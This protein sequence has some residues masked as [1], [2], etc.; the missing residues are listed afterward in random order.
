MSRYAIKRYFSHLP[1]NL[2]NMSSVEFSHT[3]R[4]RVDAWVWSTRLAK[5]RS[6]AAA[7]CRSGHVKVNDERVKPSSPVSVGD[8]VRVLN[9]SGERIVEVAALVS[10]RVGAPV[11][12]TCYIDHTPPPPPK[13]EVVVV[14]LRERGTGRPTKRER[15]DLD[16][17]RGHTSF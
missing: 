14:A 7:L 3:T 4:V 11:A 2:E 1:S 8:I 12:A 17:L 5:T 9:E 10:K 13:E 6:A 16:K 15:R